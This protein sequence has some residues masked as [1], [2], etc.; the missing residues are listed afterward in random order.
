MTNFTTE[1]INRVRAG[2]PKRRPLTDNQYL[3]MIESAT[4]QDCVL[5]AA[6][7]DYLTAD[8]LYN[9]SLGDNESEAAFEAFKDDIDENL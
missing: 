9:F 7:H 4:Y 3:D 2:I 1:H 6:S 5:L 8:E